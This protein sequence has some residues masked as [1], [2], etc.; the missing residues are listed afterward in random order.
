MPRFVG[1]ALANLKA[2]VVRRWRRRH[3]VARA[4]EAAAKAFPAHAALVRGPPCRAALRAEAAAIAGPD[5]GGDRRRLAQHLRTVSPRGL[6]PADADALAGCLLAELE[7]LLRGDA[8]TLAR[9]SFRRIE[10]LAGL[11]E[12]DPP[13]EMAGQAGREAGRADLV[14]FR[15]TAVAFR[16]PRVA[17]PLRRIEDKEGR[18]PLVELDAVADGLRSLSVL[19]GGPGSGKTTTLLELA[20]VVAE[21]RPGTVALLVRAPEWANS[22]AA[23]DLLAHCAGKAALI[24]RGVTANHLRSLARGGRLVVL[25][26]GWNEAPPAVLDGLRGALEILRREF[27]HVALLLAAR[28]A[29]GPVDPEVVFK[30]EPLTERLRDNVVA[31]ACPA[32]DDPRREAV[33]GDP[34]LDEITRTPLYLAAFLSAPPGAAPLRGE[35]L[36]NLLK[37]HERR[38]EEWAFRGVLGDA[39]ERY[40]EALAF[41]AVQAGSTVLRQNDARRT[42]AE[43]ARNLQA[44]GQ[45]GTAPHPEEVLRALAARHLLIR[46]AEMAQVG[47]SF[48][49]Q[50]FRDWYASFVVER[51]LRSGP[52]ASKP[53]RAADLF[54]EPAFEGALLFAAERMSRDD[55]RG[56][57]A[58][59]D[60]ATAALG[61]APMFAAAILRRSAPGAWE[62]AAARVVAFARRW[63]H[64][65]EVDRAFGF[66]LATGREE[67]SEEVWRF[68]ASDDRQVRLSA[69]RASHRARLV[70]ESFGPDLGARAL[71]LPGDAQEDLLASLVHDGSPAA[72]EAA[73]SVA[74]SS[75]FQEARLAVAEALVFRGARRLLAWL[76]RSFAKADWDACAARSI[77]E[78]SDF[79]EDLAAELTRA[80]ARRAETEPRGVGRAAA[81]LDLVGL[82]EGAMGP[83]LDELESP[84]FDPSDANGLRVIEAAAK[85]HPVGVGE[86]MRRRLATGLPV[87]RWGARFAAGP[88]SQGERA[89]LLER[90]ASGDLQS[91]PERRA[92]ARL[93]DSREVEELVARLL[94]AWASDVPRDDVWRDHVR[95]LEGA[96]GA[97]PASAVAGIL[98]RYAELPWAIAVKLL[99][100]LGEVF[101]AGADR[102]I[103]GGHPTAAAGERAAVL[104]V[105]E[106][107][108]AAALLH[109][110]RG[111]VEGAELAELVGRLELED[112]VGLIL[113]LLR[114]DLERWHRAR[115]APRVPGRPVQGGPPLVNYRRALAAAGGRAASSAAVALLGDPDFG[116][117]AAEVLR[118]LGPEH[119]LRAEGAP[120]DWIDFRA[121]AAAAEAAQASAGREEPP[122]P[123]AAAILRHLDTLGYAKGDETTVARAISFAAAAAGLPCGSRAGDV[124]AILTLPLERGSGYARL[125]GLASLVARGHSLAAGAVAPL[126]RSAIAAWDQSRW[127]DQEQ[128]FYEVDLWLSLLAF[129]D[130]PAAVVPQ[131]DGL[132]PRLSPWMLRRTIEALGRNPRG[133]A[134]NA[135]VALGAMLPAL[136]LD[137]GGWLTAI[138]A[139]WR[140]PAAAESLLKAVTSPAARHSPAWF[141]HWADDPVLSA[142]AQ[143]VRAHGGLKDRLVS[144]ARGDGTKAAELLCAVAAASRDDGDLLEDVLGILPRGEPRVLPFHF[145]RFSEAVC[146]DHRPVAGF[147]GAYDVVS[148]AAPVLRRQLFAKACEADDPSRSAAALLLEHTDRLRDE[149]GTPEFGEPRHPD[150]SRG[151]AWPFEAA[152]A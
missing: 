31:R 25:L 90:L 140:R 45:I 141:W 99:R 37:D 67:F 54:D 106:R 97:A 40:L 51:L 16:G 27:P 96:L 50:E 10:R 61:I 98:G 148:R 76:A 146:T 113:R 135:L 70:P 124:A 47:Y 30:L 75:S 100:P 62:G 19:E 132:G 145:E 102:E 85:L 118:A 35:L 119:D 24:E 65:G 56:V 127:G 129:S 8:T 92:A 66:M 18:G 29:A 130:D 138:A 104:A 21:R 110:E 83:V 64:E 134:G 151:V 117:E 63:H 125:R 93:L 57:A 41:S 88:A 13:V 5:L 6:E 111:E 133:E 1:E 128:R 78:P 46:S 114:G 33:R 87:G 77:F 11:A 23:A 39:H 7:K 116:V 59:S 53:W 4:V 26:D 2:A 91:G 84:A 142:V 136:T 94:A 17:I 139:H 101:C 149:H 131:L 103:D 74:R 32:V 121:A 52:P 81:L 95:A 108:A 34:A 152:P 86:S 3:A 60:L 105:A 38:E 80:K 147:E 9:E 144:L 22:S 36:R 71:A 112:G 150:L 44:E 137:G 55:E 107:W 69:L 79:P 122:H 115:L 82:G 58:A 12:P 68:A 123:N 43:A 14:A 48:P 42:V 73:V 143:A 89:A 126:C 109:G 15:N 20:E 120:A 49:H 72:W 28:P